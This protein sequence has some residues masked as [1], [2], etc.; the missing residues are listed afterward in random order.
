MK[1]NINFTDQLQTL[2]L[3]NVSTTDRNNRVNY[4]KWNKK[5]LLWHNSVFKQLKNPVK[6]YL[7]S[8]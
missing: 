5:I 3:S 8:M 6:I 1:E 4:A 7:N 2:L